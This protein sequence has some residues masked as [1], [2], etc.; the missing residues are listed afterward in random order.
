VSISG[1]V[2]ITLLATKELLTFSLL[3]GGS[4]R[5]R[6]GFQEKST[7]NQ[8]TATGGGVIRD[9]LTNTQPMIL[10]GQVYATAALL[11]SLSYAGLR[12]L[13]V[14]EIPAEL[15]AFLASLSLRASAIIFDIRMGPAVRQDGRRFTSTVDKG[16][17]KEVAQK[18]RQA[19]NEHQCRE[20]ASVRAPGPPRPPSQA[21]TG[22]KANC[23]YSPLMAW[24]LP[25]GLRSSARSEL[26]PS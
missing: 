1:K 17:R 25:A 3:Y 22:A 14:P 13:G 15:A 19:V 12:Y 6:K 4:N 16:G 20:S 10:C 2:E 7:S 11:G 5:D 18:R 8:V 9:V 26:V 24:K 23:C 21:S